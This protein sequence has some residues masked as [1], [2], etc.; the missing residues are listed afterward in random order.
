MSRRRLST[1]LVLM[2]LVSGPWRPTAAA[3]PGGIGY[4]L[5]SIVKLGDQV[6]DIAL[7]QEGGSFDVGP[8]ND[9][10][11]FS[12]LTTNAA[13][14][15]VLFQFTD[16]RLIP[17]VVPGREYPGGKWPDDVVVHSHDIN[18]P[19]NVA[20]S[21]ASRSEP[22]EHN[23]AFLWDGKTKHVTGLAR[24][25]MPAADRALPL[26]GY[27]SLA[28]TDS[29]EA[30]L[31]IAV[32]D[33]T[34]LRFGLFYRSRDGSLTP[35]ALPDQLLPDD[36]KLRMAL[37]P[38]L[39]NTGVV[40][41]LEGE[42]LPDQPAKLESAYVWEQDTIQPVARAG[43]VLADGGK[44]A[45][46]G[47]VWVNGG[48][49]SLLVAARLQETD[50][51]GLYRFADGRLTPLLVPGQELPGGGKYENLLGG[52]PEGSGYLQSVSAGNLAGQHVFLARL[53]DGATAAY[54]LDAA[55]K[56]SLVLKSGAATEL[57]EITSVGGGPSYAVGLNSFGQVALV[58]R[59]RDGV[60]TVVLLTPAA[61]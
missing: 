60:D 40:A 34:P 59:I 45:A 38:S 2:A 9:R 55:G 11:Q 31:S 7:K 37:F 29:N 32:D 3:T 35:V 49:R 36:Q 1:L 19:G 26:S 15:N 5:K 4:T 30:A 13:G 8:L 27:H 21:A 6:G 48:N 61:P 47:G 56:V 57:G 46:V 10:S 51:Y 44:I 41:F 54:R 18:W 39:S 28:I 24:P 33:E 58:V 25:G 16:E 14:A 17:V 12:L 52:T 22:N 20:F 43:M 42:V 53:E 23:G 50:A